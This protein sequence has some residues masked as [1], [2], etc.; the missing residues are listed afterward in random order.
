MLREKSMFLMV[1]YFNSWRKILLPRLSVKMWKKPLGGQWHF[2]WGQGFFKLSYVVM[3][4]DKRI[5]FSEVFSPCYWTLLTGAL[6]KDRQYLW[7]NSLNKPHFKLGRW[8]NYFMESSDKWI[9]GNTCPYL[10]K[11][12]LCHMFTLHFGSSV[13]SFYSVSN[14]RLSIV[15]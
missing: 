14:S 2:K 13:R 3:S 10:C 8:S 7:P 9:I 12:G 6:L 11:Y 5:G 1:F 4:L 15:L